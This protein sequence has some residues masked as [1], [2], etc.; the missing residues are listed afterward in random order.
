M[1][2]PSHRSHLIVGGGMAADAA[3]RGILAEDPDADVALLTSEAHPPYDR[4]PLSKGLWA[5]DDESRIWRE[6]GELGVEVRTGVT[7]TELEPENH[8]VVDSDGHR[9][10]YDRLLLA[11]G[12]RPW[13]LEGEDDP[14]IYFRTLDDFRRLRGMLSE[15]GG[16]AMVGGGFIGCELAASVASQGATVEHFFPEALPL[17]AVLPEAFAG[18]LASHLRS[19]GVKLHPGEGI[20]QARGLEEGIQLQGAAGTEA[21]PFP[22]VAAGLGVTPRDELARAAGLDVENGILVDAG[23]R[24]SHEAIFAAGDVANFPLRFPRP[25]AT[26]GSSE[27]TDESAGSDVRRARV[28]H[29]EHANESGML[30]GRGMAG[31]E[32]QY[33]PVPYVYSGIGSLTLEILGLHAAGDEVEGE[34][35]S[36]PDG[37]GVARFLRGGR[38]T[39]VLIWNRPGRAHRIRKLLNAQAP[40]PGL[41]LLLEALE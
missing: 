8:T 1:K 28:E 7:V 12:A 24:T 36:D 41:D 6:T 23:L 10:A 21:G 5:G 9:Y 14:V 34:V 31:A 39:G 17:E 27:S 11:T 40:D 35:P 25:G 13:R 30:A 3:A 29:E 33:D 19:L 4:P 15:G 22:A 16:M 38:V 32:V 26:E 2:G 18:L 20:V 37:R